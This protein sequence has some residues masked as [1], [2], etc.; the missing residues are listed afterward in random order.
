M[1]TNLFAFCTFQCYC[2]NIHSF[3]WYF[4]AKCRETMQR[5]HNI[6]KAPNKSHEGT[7]KW[8]ETSRR[9]CTKQFCHLFVASCML[10]WEM[11]QKLLYVYILH[12][13][14]LLFCIIQTEHIQEQF[15]I[16]EFKIYCGETFFH[17]LFNTWFIIQYTT[18]Y[19]YIFVRYYSYST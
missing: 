5:W 17:I 12:F 13:L 8:L 18:R 16:I 19:V 1:C 15:N 10:S 11:V 7:L 6:R 4:V 3:D 9:E 14:S 2:E